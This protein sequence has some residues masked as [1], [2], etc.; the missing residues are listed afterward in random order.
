MKSSVPSNGNLLNFL[1]AVLESDSSAVINLSDDWMS[2][3]ATTELS[4]KHL[5]SEILHLD[6]QIEK[7]SLEYSMLNN[8]TTFIGL[9]GV[10]E[11][12][13]GLCTES[14]RNRIKN[15]LLVSVPL[16]EKLKIQ[17][18]STEKNVDELMKLF[19]ESITKLSISNDGDNCKEF[20][21]CIVEFVRSIR[22]IH[23]L[24]LKQK[25]DEEREKR[26][27][28]NRSVIAANRRKSI[29]EKSSSQGEDIEPLPIEII[30]PDLEKEKEEYNESSE[31]NESF[32]NFCTP[33]KPNIGLEKSIDCGNI[34][35]KFHIAQ[36]APSDF[37][38]D[39]YTKKLIKI[40]QSS[41]S[42]SPLTSLSPDK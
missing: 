32:L 5:A 14:L 15:F 35:E 20:F 7:V 25:S 16:I 37:L 3:W 6:H 34:F 2:V 10:S 36:E 28:N 23:D 8:S 4:L 40:A 17:I 9:D 26:I 11:T 21:S 41:P 30:I 19:G 39:G 27:N 31:L 22:Q 13:D 1:V 24:N 29:L 33:L 42:A 18:Q 38:I 12:S